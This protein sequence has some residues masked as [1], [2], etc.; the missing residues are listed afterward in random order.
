MVAESGTAST[1]LHGIGALVAARITQ[2]D[3]QG[4]EFD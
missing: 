3:P 1:E 4:I 2:F